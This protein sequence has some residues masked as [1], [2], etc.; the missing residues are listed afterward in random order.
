MVEHNVYCNEKH[1]QKPLSSMIIYVNLMVTNR[2][3]PWA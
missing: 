1:E 3:L 2:D